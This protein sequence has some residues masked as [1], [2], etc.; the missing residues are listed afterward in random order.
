MISAKLLLLIILPIFLVTL[1]NLR[2]LGRYLPDLTAKKVIF[3][4][5]EKIMKTARTQPSRGKTQ[6]EV[7]NVSEEKVDEN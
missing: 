5:E 7:V 1:L 4:T 2:K 6:G 3:T